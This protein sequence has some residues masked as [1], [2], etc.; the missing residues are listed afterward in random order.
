M[1]QK[2]FDS[3]ILEIHHVREEISEK[4]DGDITRIAEDAARRQAA[5]NRPIWQ[6]PLRPNKAIHPTSR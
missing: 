4:F 1:K 3:T 6:P 2:T 5:S